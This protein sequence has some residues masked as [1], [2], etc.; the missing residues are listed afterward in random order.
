MELGL[1]GRKSHE[2]F[3][4]DI[5]KLGSV[6]QRL[7]ILQ[8]LLDTDGTTTPGASHVS[9]STT[10]QRLARDVQEIAWSLALLWQFHGAEAI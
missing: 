2:K 7:S 1:H 5:Y 3:V 6:E 9:F 10:S 8:G 4:P